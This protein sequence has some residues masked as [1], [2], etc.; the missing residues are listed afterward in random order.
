MGIAAW[1]ATWKT[2]GALDMPDSWIAMTLALAL[3]LLGGAAPRARG[4]AAATHAPIMVGQQRLFDV[5]AL[6]DKPA[7]ERADVINRRIDSFVRQPE[8]IQPVE[9]RLRG[10]ERVLAVGGREI[11]TVTAQDA[12][13]NLTSVPLLAEGWR[14][15]LDE[16]LS[17]VHTEHETLWSQIS[18][19]IVNSAQGL[20]AQAAA[21]IPRLVS[22]VLV[23][24]LT[25]AAARG[26][27]GAATRVM[28]RAGVEANT[29]QIVQTLTYYSVWAVGW[30]VALGTL[31][32]D[33][34][35]LVAGLGVTTIAL[36]FA[37]KDL[38]SNLASGFLILTTRPFR[39]GDQITVK[40][41]EGTVERIDLRA[42]LLRTYDHR[43]VIIPNADLY[44]ATV[45][46]NTAAPFR[47]QDLVVGVAYD[48]DLSRAREV[49]L[50]VARETP[51]VMPDPA[52]DI[53]VAEL[54]DSSVTLK[55]RFY[56]DSRRVN[57][58]TVG[59][60]VRQRLKEAFDADG[61]VIPFPTH[62]M[63]LHTVEP[64]THAGTLEASAGSDS[65]QQGG[66]KG[67]DP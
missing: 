53:L 55:L 2:P 65:S 49:A 50:R 28:G 64:T 7:Q 16:A 43:L 26:S 30:V 25:F 27:R 31:G 19:A 61:I 58:L 23:L 56:T 62:V 66:K 40:E 34:A 47:R 44:T 6:P 38:L 57:W 41:Y 63:H 67:A 4:A 59:S 8:R 5:G 24:L 36:G 48:T 33:P 13:D 54:A 46:N 11:L 14:T 29:Q 39:L 3:T 21:L 37:L 32:I 10:G 17:A 9:V 15:E 45:I 1:L 35:S 20:L 42:T 52:P 60:E 12:A 18:G 51:G 22:M